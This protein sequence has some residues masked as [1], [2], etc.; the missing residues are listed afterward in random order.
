MLS[1]L[2]ELPKKKK[3]KKKEITRLPIDI[4]S[5][6]QFSFSF[7]YIN[8]LVSGY[9]MIISFI[10]SKSIFVLSFSSIL[11]TSPLN[12][13]LRFLSVFMRLI[14]SPLIKMYLHM[15]IHFAKLFI[16]DWIVYM[17][18]DTNLNYLF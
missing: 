8:L 15:L 3:K 13:N 6:S 4:L 9:S 16:V 12:I 11:L 5:Q 14:I 10:T 17:L 1:L 7:C 18:K 2:L